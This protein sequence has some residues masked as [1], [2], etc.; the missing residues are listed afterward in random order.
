[1]INKCIQ[2]LAY[3]IYVITNS[4]Q[5]GKIDYIIIDENENS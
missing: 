1:M 4:V 5:I 2:N 3:E